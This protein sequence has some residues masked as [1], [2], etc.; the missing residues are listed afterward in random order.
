MH[1]SPEPLT[2]NP[3]SSKDDSAL[4]QVVVSA[5]KGLQ[6]GGLQELRQACWGG[7][8]GS[9]EYSV[10]GIYGICCIDSN[11][12][13]LLNF[14]DEILNRGPNLLEALNPKP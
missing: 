2:L 5:H 4:K 9:R 13:E 7:G 11:F 14:R 1:L 10:S 12:M 6:Y 3:K 8:P